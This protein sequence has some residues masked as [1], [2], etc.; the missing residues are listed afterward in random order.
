M[1]ELL[2]RAVAASW[3][4]SSTNTE[5]CC[6]HRCGHLGSLS[7]SNSRARKGQRSPLT[8]VPI[9][10]AQGDRKEEVLVVVVMAVGHSTASAV[11]PVLV[12][13]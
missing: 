6:T 1:G 7:C 10:G 13:C 12:K 5:Q 4:W 8:C 11:F 9:F 3:C 2:L